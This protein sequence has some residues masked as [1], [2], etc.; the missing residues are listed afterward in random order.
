M[1]LLEMQNLIDLV[2]RR[3][4]RNLRSPGY[5]DGLTASVV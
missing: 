4:L 2:Y 1:L 3:Q 5:A